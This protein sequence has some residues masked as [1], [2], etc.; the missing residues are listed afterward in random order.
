MLKDNNKS[1]SNIPN[2]SIKKGSITKKL[3]EFIEETLLVFQKQFKGEIDT[4]EEVLNE[5]LG[6][7]LNYLSKPLPFI[8]QQEAIQKQKKGQNRKVDIGVFKHYAETKPFFTIEAKRLT[9]SLSKN[10]EKEYVTGNDPI[11]LSGGIE[12]FKHNMHGTDLNKSAL[13]AYVQ[14]ENSNHWFNKINNWIN[15][16]INNEIESILNWT[17]NDLLTN[18]CGFKD[19]RLAKFVSISEKTN[20]RKISLNHYF[21][22]LK[23]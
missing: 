7:T 3:T 21:V 14:K 20:R 22:N 10:R 23:T 5:H 2:P 8:F 18:T 12:R 1:I 13:I 19:V 16:L 4:S 15:Q 9:T 17:S 6:K 11:K